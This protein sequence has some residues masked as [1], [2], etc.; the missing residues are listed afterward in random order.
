MH[1]RKGIGVEVRVLYDLSYASR[2]LSGI[3]SDTRSIARMLSTIFGS[4]CDFIIFP[5]SYVPRPR[6]SSLSPI[7]QATYSGSA[8][9]AN[10]GRSYLPSSISSILLII[11]SISFIRAV[12]VFK[13]D[14]ITS[15]SAF[16]FLLLPNLSA[17]NLRVATLSNGPRFARPKVLKC[18]KVKTKG[19]N[20]FIQ[21]QIDPIAVSRNTKHV[22]RL[23]DF[24]PI[25][26]PQFFDP[27][28]VK[29]FQY[30]LETM[31]KN[32]EII[33]VFD[34]KA[35]STE[36][37]QLF[38][39]DRTVHVIPCEVGSNFKEDIEIQVKDENL[40]VVL[41]TIE[42]RKNVLK[43]IEA[44]KFAKLAQKLP[45]DYKLAILGSK[46]WQEESLYLKL[47]KRG[48]G[49]DVIF[50]DSPSGD[51]IADVLRRGKI[52][53]S[54]S[55]AEGFGLPPLEGMLFG[56]IPVVSDI[57]QHRENLGSHGIFFG[58]SKSELIDALI[59]GHAKA[60]IST[61]Q[62]LKVLRSY[63]H[64]NFSSLHISQL[65]KKLLVT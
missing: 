14:R 13:L 26:H 39:T 62:D 52:L 37:L 3:P 6:R 23:H 12:P 54:A 36:F 8:L 53:I 1:S 63:V 35:T 17:T 38:G 5:K 55:S 21:Q 34:T 64:K 7:G 20:Y 29:A 28:A 25:T 61:V 4:N 33:W 51:E 58:E 60:S 16:N 56:C 65:W 50:K 15:K 42:P 47:V 40:A 48:F 41:N 24:L 19:Y 32:K 45:Q 27:I 2:G 49:H 9:R 30:G 10:S 57:P 44:F 43:V 11:Q 59:E 18:F 31:L 22:V 46:G